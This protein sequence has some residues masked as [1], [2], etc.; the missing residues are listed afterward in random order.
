[1]MILQRVKI[2]ITIV[3]PDLLFF[4]PL[5]WGHHSLLPI[6]LE[7]LQQLQPSFLISSLPFAL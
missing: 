7:L 3:L 4:C 1:M 2:A 5:S 6:A